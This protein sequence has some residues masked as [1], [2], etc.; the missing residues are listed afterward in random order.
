MIPSVNNLNLIENWINYLA[1]LFSLS[2]VEGSLP[3]A[4]QAHEFGSTEQPFLRAFF[5]MIK[6]MAINAK[7]PARTANVI[8]KFMN[9]SIN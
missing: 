5:V 2:Q 6:P 4:L 8:R 3:S 1:G 7:Q 9:A